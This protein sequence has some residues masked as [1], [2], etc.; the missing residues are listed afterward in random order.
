MRGRHAEL[1]QEL[2][3][4]GA[5]MGWRGL[6]RAD[7]LLG[8]VQHAELSDRRRL[9]RLDPW[10]VFGGVWRGHAELY[11]ELH[12]P[13]AAVGRRGLLRVGE[14]LDCVQYAGLSCAGRRANPVC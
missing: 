11:Q 12:E 14:L 3:K 8:R 13:G 4:P 1:F 2:H 9:E 7:E 10:S 6:Q 5:A